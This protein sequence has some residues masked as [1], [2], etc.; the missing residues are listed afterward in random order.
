MSTIESTVSTSSPAFT[1]NRAAPRRDGDARQMQRM[2]FG[3]AR[4]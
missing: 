1:E 3:V 4:P 2:Q